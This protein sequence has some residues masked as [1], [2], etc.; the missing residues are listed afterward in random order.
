MNAYHPT[1][2]FDKPEF[3]KENNSTHFL[4]LNIQIVGNEIITDLYR[5]ETDKPTACSSEQMFE[6][7]LKE[8]KCDFLMPRGYK[9]KIVDTQFDRIRGLP[10]NN[11]EEKR[12]FSLEKQT[13]EDKNKDRIIVPI[14]YNPHIAK[15]SEVMRKH[16]NAMIKKNETLQEFS[17]PPLCQHL[18]SPQT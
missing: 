8:L 3:D 15:P 18:G 2:K 17:L 16:Y 7:R 4:D 6:S 10:G 14:D 1:M 12:L 11:F 13:K 5:K 9:S